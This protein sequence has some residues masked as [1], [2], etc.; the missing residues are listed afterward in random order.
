MDYRGLMGPNDRLQEIVKTAKKLGLFAEGHIPTLSG[1]ELSDYLSY[2]ISSDH[3]LTFE[4][5]I[6]EQISKGLAVM[7]QTKSVTPE[8]MAVVAALPDRSH[9]LLITDDIEPS[10][11]KDGHLS[12]IVSLAID[13]GMPELEAIAAATIRPARYLGL[14][15]LG[16]IA[17]GFRADFM[18]METIQSFPPVAVY[19]NGEQVAANGDLIVKVQE[20]NL[21]QPD[22][23]AIPGPFT[24][25][26]FRIASEDFT[27]TALAHVVALQ[28]KKTT[29]TKLE[30]RTIKIR[31]GFAELQ[32][33]DDLALTAVIARNGQSRSVGVIANTGLQRGAWAGS[34]AHDCHN[35]MVIGRDPVAMASAANAVY[36]MKGGTAVADGDVVTAKLAL[37]FFGLLSDDPADDVAVKLSE[38]ETAMRMIG[39]DQTRPFLTFS[40]MSLSVSPFVK[41]TDRGVI[42]T[43]ERKLLP[44]IMLGH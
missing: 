19:T 1:T 5:K 27:G 20:T 6:N 31:D 24:R 18:V 44:S 35:L 12:R 8:N 41:F 3:T 33:E 32:A 36:E 16:A 42:D 43:E 14:R 11:L 23:P 30:E 15:D 29:L 25:D 10:L 37:P 2:G 13:C 34:I 22:Y 40:I 28:N 4:A 17:P 21:P 39:A 9:I 7:L 26:N 38:I